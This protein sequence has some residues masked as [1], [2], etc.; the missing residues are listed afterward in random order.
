[1]KMCSNTF[2]PLS[3]KCVCVCVCTIF[4][5]PPLHNTAG[6]TWWLFSFIH[7][8]YPLIPIQGHG[9][10]WS[11]SQL[12]LGE[13]QGTTWTGR[14]SITGLIAFFFSWK[15]PHYPVRK[16]PALVLTWKILKCWFCIKTTSW[17]SKMMNS[18][19]S[20]GKPQVFYF[21]LHNTLVTAVLGFQNSITTWCSPVTPL[22][23]EILYSIVYFKISA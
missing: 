1:M 8:L 9:W 18:N 21:H 6:W 15:L 19:D 23:C 16:V 12:S 2:H 22:F 20:T 13:R 3:L 7:F 11:L 4:L 17:P 14:Q 10:G 5:C